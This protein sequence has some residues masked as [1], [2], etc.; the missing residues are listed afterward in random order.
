M[1]RRIPWHETCLENDYLQSVHSVRVGSKANGEY[2]ERVVFT[3]TSHVFGAL[4]MRSRCGLEN[5]ESFHLI[6]CITN[7]LLMYINRSFRTMRLDFICLVCSM[8]CSSR[9]VL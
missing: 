2:F 5:M 8:N 3:T 1:K 4:G 6:S 7:E 9:A